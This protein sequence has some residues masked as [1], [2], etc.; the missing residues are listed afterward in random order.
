MVFYAGQGTS[1]I[2]FFLTLEFIGKSDAIY[3]Y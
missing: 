3:C 1:M 2:R